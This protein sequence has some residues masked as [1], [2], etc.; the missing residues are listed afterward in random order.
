MKKAIMITGA[1]SGFGEA[2][3]HHFSQLGFSLALGARRLDRLESLK[4]DIERGDN[5]FVGE[6]DVQSTQSVEKFVKAATQKLGKIHHLVNNAGLAIGLETISHAVEQD[7]KTM[8]ETN[9]MGVVRVTHA[10][11]PQLEAGSK[12]INIGSVS[13][14]ETYEGGGA[15]C[16]SKFALRAVTQTMRYELMEKGITVTS[17]DPGMAETE[18]SNVRFKQDGQKA[19]KVY[20]G[21]KP[22][23]AEDIAEVAAFIMTRPAHVN[24]ESILVMPT[25]QST[26]KRVLR[27]L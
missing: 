6:L 11:L 10:V 16:S 18:F 9:V 7:W 15:Y 17:I 3:A 1:S 24:I 5:V 27:K 26:G 2:M 19:K 25:A 20:E 14:L 8:W 4:K 13:G 22:L 12:I 23:S 21:L